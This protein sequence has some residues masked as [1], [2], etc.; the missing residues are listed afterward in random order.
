MIL[1]QKLA[2]MKKDQLD[3]VIGSRYA[4]G[5]SIGD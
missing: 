3:L 1:P 4:K 5:G 2:L